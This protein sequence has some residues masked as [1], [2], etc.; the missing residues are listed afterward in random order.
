MKSLRAGGLPEVKEVSMMMKTMMI[1]MTM[2][3][4]M[5][6]MMLGASLTSL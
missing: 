1:M 4:T 3:M 2:T 6:V 5:M